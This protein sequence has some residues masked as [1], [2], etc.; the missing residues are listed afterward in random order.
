MVIL[1]SVTFNIADNPCK[2]TK[3]TENDKFMAVTDIL[4]W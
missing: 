3:V 4:F 2:W 1:F